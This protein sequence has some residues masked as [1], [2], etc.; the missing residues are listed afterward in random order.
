MVCAREY[1]CER[2]E[3]GGLRQRMQGMVEEMKEESVWN[4]EEEFS[5]LG[6]DPVPGL[7]AALDAGDYATRWKAAWALGQVGD[8][9]AVGPLTGCL[10][11]SRKFVAGEGE[12]TL[13][14]VASW[15][16][17]RL[18]DPR[19][20]EPLAQALEDECTD[21]AWIAA[22]ALGEI[23]DARAIGPLT[24][25]LAREDFECMWSADAAMAGGGEYETESAILDY[26]T[27]TTYSGGESPILNALEKLGVEV[28]PGTEVR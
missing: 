7:I 14:M 17:G 3:L 23:G 28:E 5:G 2:G 8:A 6:D 25:A 9:R 24:K 16:L 18:G 4:W 11:F 10:D 13:N 21:F 1:I 19:A 20:V 27:G 12:F 26:I 22:W 15:A